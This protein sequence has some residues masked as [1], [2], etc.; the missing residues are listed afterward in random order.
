MLTSSFG[1]NHV[2][3]EHE[4]VDQYGPFAIP[5]EKN[6]NKAILKNWWTKVKSLLSY[7]VNE[8]I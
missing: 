8:L 1:T 5:S 4:D 2:L 3:N 6:Y 7:R